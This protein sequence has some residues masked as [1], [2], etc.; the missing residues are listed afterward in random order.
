MDIEYRK[1]VWRACMTT[2]WRLNNF[3]K[4]VLHH[5]CCKDKE[6]TKRIYNALSGKYDASF[7]RFYE[8]RY[9]LDSHLNEIKIKCDL[10]GIKVVDCE[11]LVGRYAE[12][13]AK[14]DQK[15]FQKLMEFCGGDEFV[16]DKITEMMK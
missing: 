12:F 6:F 14:G 7:N 1:N 5:L 11:D 4:L 9:F 8:R 16:R 15:H 3:G 2:D 13:M 10:L